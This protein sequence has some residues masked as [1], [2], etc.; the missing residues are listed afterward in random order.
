MLYMHL[1]PQAPFTTLP[2][3]ASVQSSTFLT[4]TFWQPKMKIEFVLIN[5]K[6]IMYIA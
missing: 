1:L 6:I 5:Y 3:R 2:A 4:D